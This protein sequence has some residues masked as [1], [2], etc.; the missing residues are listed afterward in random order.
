MLTFVEVTDRLPLT[1]T[2][3]L[4]R[5]P[6]L[7]PADQMPNTRAAAVRLRCALISATRTKSSTEMRA[8]C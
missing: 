6:R 5:T 3:L 4:C 2:L 1:V 8:A 7:A